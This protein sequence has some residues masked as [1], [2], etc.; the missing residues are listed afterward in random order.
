MARVVTFGEAM[1]RLSPPCRQRLEQARELEV[2][3][4]G[5][6][7][8]VAIGLARLGTEAAWVSRLPRGPLGRMIAAHARAHGVHVADVVWAE[9]GRLGLY[10]V[11]VGDGAR[12]SSAY[13]DRAGSAFAELDPDD[14]DW[15]AVLAGADALHVSGITPALSAACEIA[16]ERSVSEAAAAG[17]H[18]S[19]D[20][21][22]RRKLTTPESARTTLERLTPSLDAVFASRADALALFPD[23]DAPDDTAS[24]LR[25]ELGVPLVVESAAAE[26]AR[27]R[28]AAGD[29]REATRRPWIPAV[30]PIGSGDAFCAGFLHAL[31]GG[32]PLREALE[33]GDAV[34]VLKLSI[35]GDAPLLTQED[36]DALL[37]GRRVGVER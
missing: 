23:L 28:T 17:L 9:S 37:G 30:D 27:V 5:A 24:A 11:E 33:F 14:F 35:P 2:W 25:A 36:V 13:Y 20:V 32:R 29:T 12:P 19:Y 3:P 10:F 22:L 4:A 7:L 18:V 6:E 16:T 21:N 31:L 1:L 15:P 8:N 26:G 34:S